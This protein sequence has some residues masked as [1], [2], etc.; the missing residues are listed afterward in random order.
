MMMHISLVESLC[1]FQKVIHTLDDRD[2]V[3]T[4]I[5]GTFLFFGI[6]VWK[7]KLESENQECIK[8]TAQ[9]KK[10]YM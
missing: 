9:R 1:G 6:F 8:K 2:L 5:P 4:A 3:I 10:V 7:R